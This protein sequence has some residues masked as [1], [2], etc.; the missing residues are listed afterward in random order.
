MAIGVVSVDTRDAVVI[1][2][3]C[4]DLMHSKLAAVSMIDIKRIE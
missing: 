4:S 1:E 2:R 3:K